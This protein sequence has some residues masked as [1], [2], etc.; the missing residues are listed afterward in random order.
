MTYFSSEE[1][2][3]AAWA[4]FV[5]GFFKWQCE[6]GQIVL[7]KA[8]GV[9]VPRIKLSRSIAIFGDNFLN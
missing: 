8:C 3:V 5:T 2:I 9:P 6:A 4:D 7:V 1:E